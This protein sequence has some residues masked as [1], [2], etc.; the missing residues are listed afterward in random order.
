MPSY[1][2]TL[3]KATYTPGAAQLGTTA[4]AGTITIAAVPDNITVFSATGNQASSV[5]VGGNTAEIWYTNDTPSGLVLLQMRPQDDPK[6]Y[7]FAPDNFNQNQ[8]TARALKD[9]AGDFLEAENAGNIVE[10][11]VETVNVDDSYSLRD[12]VEFRTSVANVTINGESE[13]VDENNLRL[14][15]NTIF[16]FS[17][18]DGWAATLSS[19]DSTLTVL[20]GENLTVSGPN[21]ITL[22]ALQFVAQD[23]TF[24]VYSG[25]FKTASSDRPIAY[26][27]AYQQ[28][29]R[30]II[31]EFTNNAGTVQL[32]QNPYDA[33]TDTQGEY[34]V[35]RKFGEQDIRRIGFV[36]SSNP[37]ADGSLPFVP[38]TDLAQ[39]EAFYDDVVAVLIASQADAEVQQAI[40]DEQAKR[41][42]I[43]DSES[44]AKGKYHPDPGAAVLY[45]IRYSK[46]G[47]YKITNEDQGGL[48][49]AVYAADS[50]AQAVSMATAK[51]KEY[52]NTNYNPPKPDWAAGGNT[53]LIIGVSV[54]GIASVIGLIVWLR[55]RKDE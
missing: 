16:E 11:T 37:N 4:A 42:T 33:V 15:S 23:G 12:I 48:V 29:E 51:I 36:D 20:K 55:M 52:H 39:A 28:G 25:D 50:D 27:G 6:W 34:L 53:W 21:L 8:P 30:E 9:W 3:S 46:D 5:T 18:N 47:K 14:F 44:W 10:R 54:L 45:N 2:I 43:I 40:A 26:Y 41:D 38:F 19:E 7:A 49:V 13:W 31:E 32:V 35:F 24:E 17:P 1:P 22:D